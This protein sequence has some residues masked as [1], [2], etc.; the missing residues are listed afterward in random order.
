MIVD[1]FIKTWFKDFQF[2]NYCIRSINKFTTGF[3]NIVIV[4]D[5]DG[6]FI[7]SHLLTSNCKVFYVKQPNQIPS[8]VQHGVGYLWQQ[9]VKLN[10]IQW[11][12]ADAVFMIDSDCML[13]KPTT[14]ESFS[15][16][17]KF[18]WF[19]RDWDKAG[20]AQCWKQPTEYLLQQSAPYEAMCVNGFMLTREVTQAF[21]NHICSKHHV[22]E[23]WNV[24]L[25][26]N[27]SVAS[28]FNMIGNFI[29][30]YFPNNYSLLV[31]VDVNQYHNSSIRASWSWG[32]LDQNEA[33]LR[34]SILK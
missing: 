19:F 34:E 33:Q 17:G 18:I 29:Y 12:D 11:S 31:N 4:T 22:T 13:T 8:N 7:P 24:F 10:W 14:P 16:N 5:D 25:N 1:I 32:G 26:N 15:V 20:D 3:R 9:N 21:K 28:E 2:L 27:T 23:I 6:H 30:H